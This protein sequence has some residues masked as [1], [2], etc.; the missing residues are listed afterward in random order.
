MYL[1]RRK[2]LRL[3]ACAAPLACVG[4]AICVEP[5]WLAVRRLRL[6]DSPTLRLAHFSDL[7]YK[8]DRSFLKKVVCRI[9]ELSPS[10]VCFTGDLVEHTRHLSEALDVLAASPAMCSLRSLR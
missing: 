6:T 2:L 9:N 10:F 8:G 1:S 4:D 7:H 3:L 5:G